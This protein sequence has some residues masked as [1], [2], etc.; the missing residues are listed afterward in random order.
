[1]SRTSD[2]T[3]HGR[4][5]FDSLLDES[6]RDASHLVGNIT[7][8]EFDSVF[9]PRLDLDLH[10][11]EILNAVHYTD[12]DLTSHR[13]PS[14]R[15]RQLE[16]RLGHLRGE[17]AHLPAS[18]SVTRLLERRRDLTRLVEQATQEQ[19]R[20]RQELDGQYRDL[21]QRIEQLERTI[22]RQRSECE[23]RH[24]EIHRRRRDLEETWRIAQQAKESFLRQ[25]REE[26]AELESR[27]SRWE[28]ILEEVRHRLADIESR[29]RHRPHESTLGETCLVANLAEQLDRLR[30]HVAHEIRDGRPI[31]SSRQDTG[32][33]GAGAYETGAALDDLRREVSHVCRT[34]HDHRQD[35][36]HQWLESEIDYL[37]QCETL[38]S[39]WLAKLH[40]QCDHVHRELHDAERFGLTLV[41]GNSIDRELRR[42]N[43]ADVGGCWFDE[44]HPYSYDHESGERLV[45]RGAIRAVPHSCD[46]YDVAHPDADSLLRELTDRRE[47]VN[48]EL[49]ALENTADSL[50]AQRSD[51]DSRMKRL[52]GYESDGIRRELEEIEMR[53]HDAEKR[54]RLV[55]EIAH[56]EDELRHEKDQLQTSAVIV[57]ASR[58]VHQLTQGRFSRV[59]VD[60][61]RHVTVDDEDGFALNLRA[62]SRE[63]RGD[64]YL[65]IC[66]ALIKTY[67]RQGI[68]LPFV[69]VDPFLDTSTG[70]DATRATVIREFARDGHQV[71]LFS[72]RRHVADLFR[73]VDHSLIELQPRRDIRPL[74]SPPPELLPERRITETET[75]REFEDHVRFKRRVSPSD[76]DTAQSGL[77]NRRR[78]PI[79]EI[80]RAAAASAGRRDAPANLRT[81]SKTARL[82]AALND[83]RHSLSLTSSIDATG[84]VSAEVAA[85]LKEAEVKSVRDFL[86]LN[87]NKLSEALTDDGFA[88]C[89]VRRWQEELALRCWVVGL[90]A[91]DAEFLV[92][93]G[94]TD[95]G[96][97]AEFESDELYDVLTRN[98]Q[99]HHYTGNNSGRLEFL[100]DRAHFWVRGARR[101]RTDWDRFRERTFGKRDWRPGTGSR[102]S[103]SPGSPRTSDASRRPQ[104]S[105]EGQSELTGETADPST[106]VP[107]GTDSSTNGTTRNTSKP[108]RFF[109][110]AA[111]PLEDAPSIGPRTAEHFESIGVRSIGDFLTLNPDD[112]AAKI[113]KRRIKAETIRQWQRQASLACRVPELRGHDAQILVA[114]GIK[115]PTELARMEPSELWSR[116]RPFIN[117]TEGK[118]IIRNGKKPDLREIE[119]WI[120]RAQQARTMKAA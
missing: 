120:S 20:R 114:C 10:P 30:R 48:R 3:R 116:V 113:G 27:T 118:R 73:G 21:S 61:L 34:L 55:R 90:T 58:I 37:G 33:L 32:A 56:V 52:G 44:P 11:D 102:A 64:V 106:R 95:V 38:M 39:N 75:E 70:H 53:V 80:G 105:Q 24:E 47:A 19:L 74:P 100:R 99:T 68:E 111:D 13:V 110:N 66:L 88:T 60:D 57:E 108:L 51:V 63:L 15:L 36:K 65:A 14:E 40:E 84:V 85:W 18:D 117:T 79:P 67:R 28:G 25:R 96:Q 6:A 97:L 26:L 109:L 104:V 82:A 98:M 112:T 72:S 7:P 9:A 42:T 94:I 119:D 69:L 81:D 4:L 50:A 87:S 86:E 29:P 22:D 91:A 76:S 101:S 89:P 54:E 77:E 115:D 23:A 2:G 45:R 59:R 62:A 92:A 83:E 78:T 1:M 43:H 49:M 8:R 35:Y 46:G 5:S 31:N 93:C 16:V 17:L 71:L 41:D 103:T 107:T 12:F